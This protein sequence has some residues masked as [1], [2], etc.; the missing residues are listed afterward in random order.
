MG[1]IVDS[2]VGKC[3]KHRVTLAVISAGLVTD[4]DQQSAHADIPRLVWG[5]LET[6][7]LAHECAPDEAQ[8]AMKLYPSVGTHASSLP[9]ERIEQGRGHMEG[10]DGTRVKIGGSTMLLQSKKRLDRAENHSSVSTDGFLLR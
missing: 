1:P 8:D 10:T 7:E 4:S 6:D 5:A 9:G 2:A 3:A